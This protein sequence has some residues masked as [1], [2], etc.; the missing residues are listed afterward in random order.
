VHKVTPTT[1]TPAGAG[2]GSGSAERGAEAGSREREAEARSRERE[3]EAGSRERAVAGGR[4][5]RVGTRNGRTGPPVI[6]CACGFSWL[7]P[8]E[9]PQL[10]GISPR[11]RCARR[12]SSGLTS[13]Y[14]RG[15][16]ST[17]DLVGG[18]AAGGWVGWWVSPRRRRT[19]GRSAPGRVRGRRP[20]RAPAR[21]GPARPGRCR[22]ARRA[23]RSGGGTPRSGTARAT[24]R[25]WSG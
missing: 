3:A 8:G 12:R 7:I 11:V 17:A 2:A 20:A 15:G 21:S 19:R 13:G 18:S 24:Y 1:I 14:P 23:A 22:S 25:R 5:G 4:G 6:P 16:L 10:R 9:N